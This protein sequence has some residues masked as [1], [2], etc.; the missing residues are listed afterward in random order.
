MGRKRV[1]TNIPAL[2]D[3]PFAKA[4]KLAYSSQPLT[5]EE[6]AERL[7]KGTETI[8]RYFTDPTYNPPTH[9][10]PKLCKIVG[11]NILL[12]WQAAQ[13][14]GH[15]VFI[16]GIDNPSSMEC[17][18]ATLTKEFA[19]VLE[20]YGKAKADGNLDSEELGRIEK[21][22]NDLVVYAEGLRSSIQNMK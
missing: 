1:E 5:Y 17:K 22:L 12:E 13:V 3:I 7:G 4:L 9:L 2:T 14:G 19:D 15:V 10:V 8:R 6:I 18:I 21:E 11:N 16:E 20:E